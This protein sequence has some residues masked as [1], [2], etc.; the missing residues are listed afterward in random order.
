MKTIANSYIDGYLEIDGGK[1]YYSTFNNKSNEAKNSMIVLHGSAGKL[2]HTYLLPQMLSLTNNSAV[3]FYDQRGIGKSLGFDLTAEKINMAAHT[4]DLSA[5]C[6][7]LGYAKTILI[8]H[9]WG[10]L[11]A[12]QYAAMYPQN[13]SKLILINPLPTT[14]IGYSALRTDLDIKNTL[15]YNKFRATRV[16]DEF[17]FGDD[18]VIQSYYQEFYKEYY[19]SYFYEPTLISELSLHMSA[20]NY[21]A[22]TIIRD[23]LIDTYLKSYDLTA[24]LGK[25]NLPVLIIHGDHDIMPQWTVI[26]T[27][28]L[29]RN[30]KLITITNCGHFAYI[31]QPLQLFSAIDQFLL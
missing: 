30:S 17:R 5:L 20:K 22:G 15:I 3:T 21:E 8:G 12:I 27:H 7:K 18:G 9:S 23:T 16:S 13:I 14:A 28:K 10:C 31:E 11:L 29:I 4:K 25:L 6:A 2:D 26:Q 19:A 1:I 24:D